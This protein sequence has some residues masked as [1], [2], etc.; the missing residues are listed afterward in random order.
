MSVRIRCACLGQS[1]HSSWTNIEAWAPQ[2]SIVGPLFFLIYINN[3]CDGLTSNPKLFADDTSLFSVVHNIN[4]TKNDLTNDLI[5]I[6]N[7]AFEWKM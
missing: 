1:Q 4:S 2:G 3:L 5:K 6:S 7:W